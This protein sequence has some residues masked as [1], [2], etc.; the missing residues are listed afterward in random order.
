M[1]GINYHC[2]DRGTG[3]LYRAYARNALTRETIFR[4][5]HRL[6]FRYDA[7]FTVTANVGGSSVSASRAGFPA[8]KSWGRG[9][10]VEAPGHR[11]GRGM[12][13]SAHGIA[14]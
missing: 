4:L 7:C 3:S 2:M 14:A 10:R 6:D 12:K 9:L 1:I 5:A 13:G 11:N 8:R